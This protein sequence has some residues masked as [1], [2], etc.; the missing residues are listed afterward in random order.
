MASRDLTKLEEAVMRML[1]DGDDSS[2]R[3][4]RQQFA[5]A[6]LHSRE[7]TGVGFYTTFALPEDIER[8]PGNP[9]ISFGDVEATMPSLQHGACFVLW[10]I[11]SR[12]NVLE[13]YTYDEPWP[14]ETDS[15]TLVYIS[16]IRDLSPLH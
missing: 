13:G 7:M 5:K 11:D 16:E 2:L 15:F 8:L 3:I 6:S 10:I 14:E 4:L 9:R 1:L 12:L